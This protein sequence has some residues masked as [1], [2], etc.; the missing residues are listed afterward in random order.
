MRLSKVLEAR[1]RLRRALQ[2]ELQLGAM[3][4]LHVHGWRRLPR[5]VISHPLSFLAARAMPP[6]PTFAMLARG[7]TNILEIG[8]GDGTAMLGTLNLIVLINLIETSQEQGKEVE[9]AVGVNAMAYNLGPVGG[10]ANVPP[11]SRSNLFPHMTVVSG[12]GSRE[13]FSGV[14]SRAQIPMPRRTPTLA[15]DD[16][17]QGLRLP[18]ASMDLIFSSA[19]DKLP[20][21]GAVNLDISTDWARLGSAFLRY[22]ALMTPCFALMTP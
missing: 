8:T 15:D 21:P 17:Y 22:T 11:L 16:Y 3:H 1:Q 14:A 19:I 7:A 2:R 12:F 20:K 9:C 4:A 6:L 10:T 13:A 18:T 5:D